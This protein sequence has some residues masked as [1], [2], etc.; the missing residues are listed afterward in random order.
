MNSQKYS[1]QNVTLGGDL[2]L[3]HGIGVPQEWD[4]SNQNEKLNFA[5]RTIQYC[6]RMG[7]QLSVPR[8]QSDVD[9]ILRL[10]KSESRFLRYFIM[11]GIGLYMLDG[12][13]LRFL[14]KI[15]D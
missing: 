3:V 9:T 12:T 13:R 11:L 14:F 7:F 2:K 10:G 4:N 15:V 8:S 1:V 6:H 5:I